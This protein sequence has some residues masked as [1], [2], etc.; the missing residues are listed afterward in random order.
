MKKDKFSCQLIYGLI[1]CT[2]IFSCEKETK[3]KN[4][5]SG[6]QALENF[7]FNSLNEIF[8]RMEIVNTLDLN[9]LIAFEEQAG[10]TSFGRKCE[11]VYF[12]IDPG[13]I[14]SIE[15]LHEFVSHNQEYVCLEPD[16]FGELEYKVVNGNNPFRYLANE[17]KIFQVESVVYKVFEDGLVST[18]KQNLAQLKTLNCKSVNEIDGKDGFTISPLKTESKTQLKDATYNCGREQGTISTNGNER[19]K[20]DI[21]STWQLNPTVGGYNVWFASDVIITPQKQAIVWYRVSREINYDLNVAIDYQINTWGRKV[22]DCSGTTTTSKLTKTVV[23]YNRD[24]T[25][26]G[27]TF[28]YHLGG[29]DLWADTPEVYPASLSCNEG[30]VD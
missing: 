13:S 21:T 10:Y 25:G 20:M 7:Y 30:L 22:D 15:V 6:L 14:N 1:I 23:S 12:S 5:E 26:T 4:E 29:Y 8:A 9:K 2:F 11:E 18:E 16:E 28:N 17:D 19:L 24:I 27:F 3:I